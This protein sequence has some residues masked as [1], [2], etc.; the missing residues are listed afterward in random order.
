MLPLQKGPN[1]K[2][3]TTVAGTKYFMLTRE[4][5]NIDG[6][7]R[8]LVAMAN[9]TGWDMNE[10][11]T[12]QLETALRD[13]ESLEMMKKYLLKGNFVNSEKA[14][15]GLTDRFISAVLD[16]IYKGKSAAQAMQEIKSSQNASLLEVYK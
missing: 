12:V 8:V 15:M 4:N 16:V 7:A 1:A 3:Y 5:K 11:D 2:G 9:R 13:E 10:W 14:R 6:A